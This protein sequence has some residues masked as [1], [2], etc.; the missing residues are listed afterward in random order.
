MCNECNTSVTEGCWKPR[1][2][3]R[4]EKQKTE[5]QD[6]SEVLDKVTA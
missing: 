1:G 4:R 2:C 6:K 5:Q 3:E